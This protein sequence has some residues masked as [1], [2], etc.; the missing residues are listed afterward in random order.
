MKVPSS[1]RQGYKPKAAPSAIRKVL[2]KQPR[3]PLGP[4]M[5]AW[6]DGIPGVGAVPFAQMDDDEICGLTLPVLQVHGVKRK[7]LAARVLAKINGLREA[8]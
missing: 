4:Q 2:A 8:R 1:G 3:E 5:A 7:Q 6:A